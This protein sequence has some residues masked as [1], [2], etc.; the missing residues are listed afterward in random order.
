MPNMRETTNIILALRAKGWTDTE[1]N[2]FM[3][4]VENNK[5]TQKQ[6]DD[7]KKKQKP[8]AKKKK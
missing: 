1:I 2:D 8:A 5:P 4:F 7:S 6:I 3:L